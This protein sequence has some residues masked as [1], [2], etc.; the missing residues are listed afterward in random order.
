MRDDRRFAP[1]LSAVQ[2]SN[3]ADAGRALIDRAGAELSILGILFERYRADQPL[4]GARIAVLC[5]LT[6]QVAVLLETL[7]R[8]G[9]R[10][11]C[12]A[13]GLVDDNVLAA[14]GRADVP[15]FA[16]NGQSRRARLESFHRVFTWE[17]GGSANLILDTDGELA[18]LI[19]S[20]VAAEGGNLPVSID[21][22]KVA[23]NRAIWRQLAVR[24]AFYSTIATNIVG[25]SEC[26]ARGVDRLRRIEKAGGLM[27]PVIDASSS[28]LPGHAPDRNRVATDTLAGLLARQALAQIELFSS[29]ASYRPGVHRFPDKLKQTLAELDAAAAAAELLPGN[30]LAEDSP[31]SHDAVPGSRRA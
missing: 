31:E 2:P 4:A 30:T 19:H 3:P 5:P 9:A 22:E 14:M 1:S 7:T 8:L 12:A 21:D 6:R 28:G 29:G 18:R 17:N 16:E 27:F 24:P 10:I 26:T 23:L 15:I 13:T 20:G 11:R 25:L